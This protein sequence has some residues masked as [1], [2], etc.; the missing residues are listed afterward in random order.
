MERPLDLLEGLSRPLLCLNLG[1]KLRR[2]LA[3]LPVV[4]SPLN[5]RGE[6]GRS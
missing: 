3:H 1:A 6:G 2:P 5:R 4:D